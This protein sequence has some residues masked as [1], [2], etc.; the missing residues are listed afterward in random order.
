[1]AQFRVYKN[2]NP[3]SRATYPLLL[4]VQ[5]ELLDGLQTR[6]VI[7]LTKATTL[8][9]RPITR[10]TPPMEVNGERYLLMTPQLA[11]ISRSELGVEVG[12]LAEQRTV[13]V[14]ALDL[15]ITGA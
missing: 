4:D 9:K 11:G 14:S 5:A 7:P 15:L 2:K 6:V 1:M 8:L 3:R 13:I 10:L 12:D